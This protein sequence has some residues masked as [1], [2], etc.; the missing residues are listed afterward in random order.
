M[1]YD[2]G[3]APWRQ[4]V[5]CT[6]HD[7]LGQ[8]GCFLC[9]PWFDGRTPFQIVSLA[10]GRS[11]PLVAPEIDKSSDEPGFFA[12]CTDRNGRRG[13][14]DS[15]ERVLHEIER[16][17]GTGRES[18]GQSIQ[19][20]VVRVEQGSQPAS[21][22]VR[23]GE[24][25]VGS[26]RHAVHIPSRRAAPGICWA[27]SRTPCRRIWM[28]SVEAPAGVSSTASRTR[29]PWDVPRRPSRPAAAP[30][31]ASRRFTLVDACRRDG[32]RLGASFER[33]SVTTTKE[34]R[35]RR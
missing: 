7:D 4:R 15:D 3:A 31:A 14:G 29:P 27:T 33:R 34:R 23:R 26:H 5:E 28:A 20:W 8:Q 1:H 19:A 24:W 2:N 22:V 17:I 25:D 30:A 6:P 11:S 18:P 13:P 21:S 35:R 9:V 10:D 16:I 32:R 12:R